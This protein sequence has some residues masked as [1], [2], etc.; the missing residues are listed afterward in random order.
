MLIK[1]E[2]L[3][4]LYSKGMDCY[5]NAMSYFNKGDKSTAETIFRYQARASFDR[6]C[7][8]ADTLIAGL[9]GMPDDLIT[10]ASDT[11]NAAYYALLATDNMFIN[12]ESNYFDYVNYCSELSHCYSI[13]ADDFLHPT[14]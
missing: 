4:Q 12:W 1:V 3:H 10:V 8:D 6:V 2:N 14:S 5:K 7:R 9:S 13:L 11:R